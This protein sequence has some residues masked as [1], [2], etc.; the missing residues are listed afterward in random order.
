MKVDALGG[1]YV[2]S[3]SDYEEKINVSRSSG[4]DRF[5]NNYK[6]MIFRSMK[7][8][9]LPYHAWGHCGARS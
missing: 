8:D 7:E 2:G 9:S 3:P 6:V 4:C 5:A 1:R